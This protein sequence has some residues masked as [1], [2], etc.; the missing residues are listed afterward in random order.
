MGDVGEVGGVRGGGEERAGEE[1]D[2]ERLQCSGGCTVPCVSMRVGVSC[3]HVGVRVRVCVYVHSC[4][5]RNVCEGA[6]RYVC[7]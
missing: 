5:C 2:A 1:G 7:V 6:H 3:A 4:A